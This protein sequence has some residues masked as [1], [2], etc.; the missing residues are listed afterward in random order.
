MIGCPCLPCSSLAPH[1]LTCD[2]AHS[3]LLYRCGLV[4]CELSDDEKV[5]R[6]EMIKQVIQFQMEDK[7]KAL[8]RPLTRDE[9]QKIKRNVYTLM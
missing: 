5:E 9:I 2:E 6:E 8:G 4:V 7:A 3:L 1:E